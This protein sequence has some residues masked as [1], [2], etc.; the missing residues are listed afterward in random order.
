MK[1]NKTSATLVELNKKKNQRDSLERVN[2]QFI[3]TFQSSFGW[4]NLISE[5]T[6]SQSFQ[7]TKYHEIEFKSGGCS[8]CVR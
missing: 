3:V 7:I 4:E 8:K 1:K 2:F 6:I 5:L